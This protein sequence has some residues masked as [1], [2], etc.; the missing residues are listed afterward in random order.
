M[1]ILVTGATGQLGRLTVEALLA[2]GVLPAQITA[3]GR[4]VGKISDLADRGVSVRRADFTDPRGLTEAFAGA[5]RLLLVSTGSPV[6]RVAEHQN[7]IDA[8][9]AAGVS[10]LAYTS[11]SHAATDRMLLAADHRE[12][13]EYLRSSGVPFVMLR[14]SWYLEYYTGQLASYL[15]H[16]TVAG[17][18][19]QG[20]VSAAARSEFAEAAAAVLTADGHAGAVY[21]LGGDQA[22]TL[23]ELAAEISAAA[24]RPVSY[25][26]MPAP[27]LA[28]MLADAGV[29]EPVAEMLADADL[30]VA[31]GELFTDSGDL[32]RLI[33]H[34]TKPLA[35]AIREALAADTR[36]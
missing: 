26:D 34:P 13:E 21:E 6:G 25:V 2:R 4:D 11:V 29:P 22:F 9:K 16:G 10:L 27:E 7:A 8:A 32:R 28:K 17:S 18:A 14:N 24:G 12:T 19:G 35:T 30:G 3:T 5:D 33:G 31:R 15:Q 36:Q 23:A 20:Q 1:S